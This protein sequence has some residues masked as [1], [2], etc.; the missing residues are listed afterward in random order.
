MVMFFHYLKTGCRNMLKY[1]ISAGIGIVGLAVGLLCF[2]LCNYCVHLLTDV[3]K[4]FPDYERIAEVRIK[5]EKGEFYAGTPSSTVKVLEDKFPAKIECLTS[6]TYP[7]SMNV[8]FVQKDGTLTTHLLQLVETDAKFRD[9]FSCRLVS[10]D[11][12]QID[13]QKNA[14]VLSSTMARKIYGEES[15]LGRIFHPNEFSF[16]AAKKEYSPQ[17][18]ATIDYVVMGVMED[19]PLNASFSFLRPLGALVFND[20][21]GLFSHQKPQDGS[22]MCNTYALLRPEVSFQE[23]NQQV[24]MARHAV[25]LGDELWIPDFASSGSEYREAYLPVSRLYL[26]IGLLILLVASLNFFMFLAGN[27]LNR[28]KEFRIRK[29]LGENRWQLFNLLFVENLLYIVLVGVLVFCLLELVY[30]RLDFGWANRSITFQISTLYI[31]LV[32]YLL[33]GIV[34]CAGVC[35]GICGW[36]SRRNIRGEVTTV[37]KIPGGWV[38][39][40]M[41]EVQL[42]ICCLFLTSSLALYQQSLKVNNMIFPGL[43]KNE[44]MNI[45]EVSLDYPQLKNRETY[46]IERL[47]A[48]PEVTE[49]LETERGVF[50]WE[51]RG[52]DIVDGTTYCEYRVINVGCNFASFLKMPVEGQ[53][54]HSPGQIVADP[55]IA[56]WL[57]G[58]ALG[59]RL[60]NDG[61]EGYEICGL[62]QALPQVHKEGKASVAWAI[63][64]HPDCVYLK[65]LPGTR[66]KVNKKVADILGEWLPA[67]VRPQIKTLQQ[68]IEDILAFQ[69][70]VG[71]LILFFTV[72]CILIT[73]LG[74]YSAITLD[75]ERRQK[76]MA[77]RKINGASAWK[78]TGLFV[79]FYARLLGVAI[80]LTF[81][82]LWW[83]IQQWL[84]NYTIHFS[85]G[86]GFWLTIIAIL[87]V[88]VALTIGWKIRNIVRVNPIEIL[89]DE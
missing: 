66:E 40:V 5:N 85:Y 76:E 26:G 31:Q 78:I 38:R 73:I 19:Q 29:G 49:I 57:G 44:K 55:G 62:T 3:D 28:L 79:R 88:V 39:S 18:L 53:V 58:N 84:Q 54:F 80:V 4:G 15:P 48:L 59:K 1:K 7:E 77:I 51:N 23:L 13:G 47:S 82:L 32:E 16:R 75:T 46:L 34:I 12:R 50:S 42:I 67:S 36:L 45:L 52:I 21:Y 71:A 86:P 68:K 83:G 17:E 37:V 10:G 56:E 72:V 65:V 20:E 87:I 25:L 64:E 6:V 74:I 43:S 2:V 27:F 33:A 14:V 70:K 9:V 69:N 30:L 60:K 8:S 63:A 24:D 35:W 89:R 11:W 61:H 22:S 41:L 81:P